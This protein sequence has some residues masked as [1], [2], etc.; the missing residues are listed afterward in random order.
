LQWKYKI[1]GEIHKVSVTPDCSRIVVV[2]K[3]VRVYVLDENGNLK[4]NTSISN[5]INTPYLAITRHGFRIVIACSN[6]VYV[7]K[8][9]NLTN[10]ENNLPQ[11]QN[12]IESAVFRPPSSVIKGVFIKRDYVIKG[13]YLKFCLEV[14]NNTSKVITKVN[15]DVIF[16]SNL[17]LK[18]PQN[19]KQ[20]LGYI[21]PNSSA[22]VIYLFEF[23]EE[24][25]IDSVEECIEVSINYCEPI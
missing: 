1:E 8:D 6:F 5:R 7:F 25:N 3:N 9:T 10:S 15:I 20:I 2:S 12:T 19:S 23:R 17:K 24:S 4:W 14:L 13:K 22:N 16:P 18:E 11:Y 21:N